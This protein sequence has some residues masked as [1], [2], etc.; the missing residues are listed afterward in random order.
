MKTA[1]RRRKINELKSA[2]GEARAR[3]ARNK[4]PE[5]RIKTETSLSRRKH[6]RKSAAARIRVNAR[7]RE[8]TIDSKY[9]FAVCTFLWNFVK[10]SLVCAHLRRFFIVS[11]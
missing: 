9:H 10:V 7:Q 8:I 1:E 11:C 6:F 2:L 5:T 4:K 3:V